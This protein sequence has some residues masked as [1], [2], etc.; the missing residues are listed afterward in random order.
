[1]QFL[2][3]YCVSINFEEGYFEAKVNE[4]RKKHVYLKTADQEGEQPN[5]VRRD[6][7]KPP[8]GR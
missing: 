4:E 6:L 2:R 3:S 7:T 8:V 1:M 5:Q